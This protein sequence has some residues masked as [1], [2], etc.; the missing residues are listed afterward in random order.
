[1]IRALTVAARQLKAAGRLTA[2]APVTA[3]AAEPIIAA[4]RDRSAGA[5]VLPEPIT[6]ERVAPAARPGE[7][8]R[9][10]TGQPAA[11]G[12][13][14]GKVRRIRSSEDLGRFTA[15]EVLVCDAI[16][17]M[18]T[19]L[20]PLACAVVERR[21]GMLIHGAIIARELRIPCVNGI[22]GVVD[23]LQDGDLVTVDGYLG[24]VTVGPSDFDLELASCRDS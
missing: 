9:Q 8:L 21:G 5:V 11:P 7:T 2:T 24:I 1:M 17:P 14:T 18:M 12:L 20:V 22:A 16:Q 23:L 10:V 4:L 3:E 15:G 19:H 13:A 6:T